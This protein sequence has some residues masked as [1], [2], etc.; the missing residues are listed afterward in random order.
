MTFLRQFFLIIDSVKS[1]DAE[2]MEDGNFPV[3]SEHSTNHEESQRSL[4]D[5]V[6]SRKK[7][8]SINGVVLK[9]NG[10]KQKKT[11]AKVPTYLDE[12][13][14][15]LLVTVK[16]VM[17]GELTCTP[18]EPVEVGVSELMMVILVVGNNIGG[19]EVLVSK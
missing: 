7:P 4:D 11:A 10:R 5:F 12:E 2:D 14:P 9:K 8:G 15:Y 18:R 6:T 1:D 16:N 13:D 3:S 17:V 19:D